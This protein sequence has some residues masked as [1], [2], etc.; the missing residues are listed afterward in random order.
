LSEFPY[1]IDWALTGRCNLSCR[2]CRG[3]AEEDLDNER[4]K[5]LIDEIAELRPG[6]VIVEGGE[7]FLRQ[8]L[9]ELVSLMRERRLNVHL[10]T[11]GTQLNYDLLKPLKLL[12][13][14]VMVSIDGAT[15]ATYEAIRYGANF[16]EVV[17][18]AHCY[19]Q[20]GL[21]EAINFT[22]LK[23][24]YQEIPGIFSLAASL[25]TKLNIIGLKPCHYYKEELLAPG[26][27]EKAIRLACQAAQD[28]K[29]P[30]F[31]DEPF[32]W[33]TVK[34]WGLTI[35][36]TEAEA[37]TGI[38][39]SSASGCIFGNY[40]FLESNGDVKPCSFAPMILGNVKK[41]SLGKIWDEVLN[42]EFF[43]KIKYAENRTG[44]CKNCRYLKD[45]MGCRSRS[46]YLTGNWFAS[47]AAC[48]IRGTKDESNRD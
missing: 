9:L 5:T 31:F 16:G 48:P 36:S 4:V 39:A 15:S 24:N 45:C 23:K 20:A 11:N 10:I 25:G 7:P 46:Y 6:W 38:L 18:S 27:Y 17:E 26:E 28:N 29:V 14:R 34:K 40:L 42:S 22:V 30:F 13:I 35:Q 32:F 3:M 37:E 41:K 33:P 1:L 19:A 47:D 43:H 44:E 12:G 8:D 21:L 2:H